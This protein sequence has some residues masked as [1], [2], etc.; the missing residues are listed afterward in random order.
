MLGVSEQILSLFLSI[1]NLRKRIFPLHPHYSFQFE[2]SGTGKKL[3]REAVNDDD[4]D[5]G[6][7]EC[8]GASYSRVQYIIQVVTAVLS[9]KIVDITK[10]DLEDVFFTLSRYFH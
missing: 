2:V 9:Q 4:D 1:R 10:E 7:Y 3:E 6:K 8:L 5:D